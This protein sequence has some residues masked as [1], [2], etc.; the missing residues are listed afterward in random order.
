MGKLERSIKNLAREFGFDIVG[1][2]TAESFPRDEK[3]ALDR[4]EHGLM[5]GLGW[6]TKE[7][8]H[9]ANRPALLVKSARSIISVA[10]SYNTGDPCPGKSGPT[11]KIARYAWGDDYHDLMKERLSK[12]VKALPAHVGHPVQT[13]IF[14]DDGPMNDRAAAER[15]GG[16]W[17]GKNSNVLTRSHGSWVLLGQIITDL[18][19]EP[20]TPLKKTCGSCVRCIDDC[21]TGAIVAP[22]TIDNTRCISFL[23]IE[24]R[25]SIPR[26]LRSLVGDWVFG[27]DIC[28]EVCPVNRTVAL[29]TEPAFQQ[30]HDFGAPALLPLLELNDDEFSTRFRNSAIKR[31]K[32]V[33]LQRNVCVALGNIGDPVSGPALTRSLSAPDPV[34]REH[35]AWA[36][37]RLGSQQTLRALRDALPYEADEVV[38]TEITL[39]LSEAEA[40]VLS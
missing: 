1:I 12:L 16:G 26:E 28:Q 31:A 39:S 22:F 18:A 10:M 5:D 4:I 34:I 40:R 30:R 11:G 8:V 14:V 38:R 29:G 36:L 37:G 6:Y 13:R 21:P 15:A 3:A 32:R 23:T 33:G 17:F 7:R 25:G 24:L 27:C 20:D 9:K 35:A 19:L 2:T